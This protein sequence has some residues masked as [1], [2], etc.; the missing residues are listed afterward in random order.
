[1]S[2][3]DREATR[4]VLASL[5][6]GLFFVSQVVFM[7][8]AAGRPIQFE[9]DILQEL[10]Y[11]VV[12]ALVSPR[13]LD[14]ARRWPLEG[15]ATRLNAWRH[16]LTALPLAALVSLAAFGLHLGT[17]IFTGDVP[18]S[19]AGMWMLRVRAS[20]VWGVFMGVLFYWLIVGGYTMLRLRARSAVLEGQLTRAQLD[21][22]RSQLNPHFLFNTLNAISVLTVEDADKARR[23]V[24]R[25][26]SLLRRSLDEA[27]HE[28]ALRKE[29]EFLDEYLD[30]Q[31]VRFGDRLAVRLTLDPA[32]A[33]ARVPVLMLQPLVENAIEHGFK[34][35]GAPASVALRAWREDGALRLTIEDNGPGPGDSSGRREGIGLRNTRERLDRLYGGTASIRL[36]PIDGPG[37]TRVD[38]TLPFR[39]AP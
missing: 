11:W 1:M 18:A 35:R 9:W 29:L 34:D 5:A 26:G 25:L 13:V 33:E 16:A 8:L 7:A 24:L 32:A 15:E 2:S 39:T 20:L 22:L 23:M 37:G 27:E 6:V 31:R 17:L 4:V 21:Q 3:A 28:V 36:E 14:L 10:L 30:I 38:L 12:W 19:G